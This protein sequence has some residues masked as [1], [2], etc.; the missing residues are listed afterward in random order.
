MGDTNDKT[1]LGNFPL[2]SCSKK[3]HK[4]N[5]ERNIFFGIPNHFSR[6][7]TLRS[8]SKKVH[9]YNLMCSYNFTYSS[10]VGETM[11]ADEQRKLY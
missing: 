1:S 6:N 8:C 4:Y 2:R 9:K 5:F 11:L 7:F 3:V 10:P